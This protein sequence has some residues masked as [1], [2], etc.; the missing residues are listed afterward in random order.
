MHTWLKVTKLR[1]TLILR[2]QLHLYLPRHLLSSSFPFNT[3]YAF[4]FPPI[5]RCQFIGS[6]IT[7]QGKFQTFVI[8]H[9]YLAFNYFVWCLLTKNMQ[10]LPL[11]WRTITHSLWSYLFYL[12]S[13]QSKEFGKPPA[14]RTSLKWI[15]CTYKTVTKKDYNEYFITNLYKSKI[16]LWIHDTRSKS[17]KQNRKNITI[18]G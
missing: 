6:I 18:I 8:N 2:S 3:L 7:K 13:N 12:Q 4:L 10:L 15:K 1:F 11:I 16:K 5:H 17:R 14:Y 9:S